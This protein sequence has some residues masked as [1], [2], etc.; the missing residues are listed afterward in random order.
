MRAVLEMFR[1]ELENALHLCGVATV[2]DVPRDLVVS[3]LSRHRRLDPRGSVPTR[4]TTSPD[5]RASV[6]G[7]FWGQ[8]P[9]TAQ[10]GS[11]PSALRH[12]RRSKFIRLVE[13]WYELL[14]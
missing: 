2:T 11:D 5:P 14:R 4:V 3:S 6:C 13:L 12:E 1:A 9:E 8:T 10:L 7:K